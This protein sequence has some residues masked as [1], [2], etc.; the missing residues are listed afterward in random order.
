MASVRFFGPDTDAYVDS[1]QRHAAE[2]TAQTGLDLEL[3]IIPSDE[4]FS[5][6]IHP[7]LEGEG[8]ADVFMSGPVLLWEHL[9]GG[10]VE[11][12]NE[13][14]A[15]AGSDF[16]LADFF[17]A[18]I[19]SNRW[20]GRFGDALGKGALLE[21]PVN[22]EAY[23]LAY[24]PAHLETHKIE[25]P[26]TWP[27]YFAAAALL[28]QRSN[29]AINGFAQRGIQVWHTMYT[30]FATQLWAYGGRDWGDFYA[31]AR[32]LVEGDAR[33]L[34]TPATNYRRLADRWVRALRSA[35]AG[36]EDVAEALERAGADIDQLVGA[37]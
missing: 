15:K 3:T 12:L 10:Y 20:T 32:R 30:G 29:G 19:A 1:V 13:H 7:Y 5:N 34:V 33:V 14:L 28:K 37:R 4:Y 16:D 2:F 23:N 11:P 25:L 9:P 24:V 21:I 31:V 27:D 6:A 35:Y 36:D 22:Y 18:L 8:A 17:P 26:R